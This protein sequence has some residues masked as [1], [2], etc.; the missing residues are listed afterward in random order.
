[1]SILY[2]QA[3]AKRVKL[4]SNNVKAEAKFHD[5]IKLV[6]SNRETRLN[7]TISEATVFP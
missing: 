3:A 5:C 1:M 2:V 6:L 7:R 4:R